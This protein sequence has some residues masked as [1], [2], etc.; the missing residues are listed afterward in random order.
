MLLKHNIIMFPLGNNF[1]IYGVAAIINPKVL[2]RPSIPIISN[3]Q[4]IDELCEPLTILWKIA[5][6]VNVL[7][8]DDISAEMID[9]Y[10]RKIVR[11]GDYYTLSKA[12]HR[13][14]Q[15]NLRP[16]KTEKLIKALEMTNSYRGIYNTKSRLKDRDLSDYKQQLHDLDR[17]G[18]NPVTIPREW[19]IEHIPNLLN[20]Y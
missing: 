16:K 20:A 10:F 3:L 12:R 4:E 1:R 9:K 18:I 14:E 7:L 17:I 15:L 19:G 6:P 2:L 13:I 8:S 5:I 11:S